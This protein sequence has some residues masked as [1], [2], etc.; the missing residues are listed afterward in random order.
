MNYKYPGLEEQFIIIYLNIKVE[1]SLTLV[2]SGI[3]NFKNFKK[4][5]ENTTPTKE[6]SHHNKTKLDHEQS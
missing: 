6:N 4:L 5:K 1:N 3:N 2:N